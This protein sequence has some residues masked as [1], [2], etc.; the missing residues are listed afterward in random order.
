M[1]ASKAEKMQENFSL[2]RLSMVDA[3]RITE[4]QTG[5]KVYKAELKRKDARVYYELEFVLGGQTVKTEVD[6]MIVAAPATVRPAPVVPAPRPV[7]PPP[8][9]GRRRACRLKSP[10]RGPSRSSRRSC[11]RRARRG[12]RRLP[13]CRRRGS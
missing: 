12:R 11:R 13:P 1:A 8:C 9:A 7:P 4:G 10:L 3:I 6:A 5:G 2:A